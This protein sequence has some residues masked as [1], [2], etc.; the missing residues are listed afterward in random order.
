MSTT[1]SH[2]ADTHP[3]LL[4]TV[5]PESTAHDS[6]TST[7]LPVSP[8]SSTSP[9]ASINSS[10]SSSSPLRP[11]TDPGHSEI[12]SS[13]DTQGQNHDRERSANEVEE[14]A[15]ETAAAAA[16]AAAAAT[17]T[18]AEQ[19]E[20]QVLGDGG[21]SDLPN[22]NVDASNLPRDSSL[23]LPDG[24][25]RASEA[26]RTIDHEQAGRIGQ[27]VEAGQAV[28]SEQETSPRSQHEAD[29]SSDDDD[30]SGADDQSDS[31]EDEDDEGH[32]S[33]S[34]RE[35]EDT[36]SPDEEELKQI[37]EAGE[38]SADDGKFLPV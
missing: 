7:P 34:A 29:E 10:N 32:Q 15:T 16:A 31:S 35:E 18:A 12:V 6:P 3:P 24:T 4:N 2:T 21:I 9:P 30:A 20:A 28:A 17:A 5:R 13:E 25:I 33:P 22:A 19:S 23:A 8:S 27:A 11:L 26:G 14:I 37:I 36:S 1:T 38:I